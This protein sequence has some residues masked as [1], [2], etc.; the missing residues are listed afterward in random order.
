MWIFQGLKPYDA[1]K[2]LFAGVSA[3][4]LSSMFL[5]FLVKSLLTPVR[6]TFRVYRDVEGLAD[7]VARVTLRLKLLVTFVSLVCLTLT[8]SAMMF[9]ERTQRALSKADVQMGR[10]VFNRLLDHVAQ[11]PEDQISEEG[12]RLLA[13]DAGL[14]HT[15]AAFVFDLEGNPVATTGEERLRHFVLDA[16]SRPEGE[17]PSSFHRPTSTLAT[18]VPGRPWHLAIFFPARLV[19]QGQAELSQTLFVQLALSLSIAIGL[20]VLAANDVN[21]AIQKIGAWSKRVARGNLGAPL[22]IEGEDEL[23]ELSVYLSNMSRRLGQMILQVRSTTAGVEKMS[24]DV[25]TVGQAVMNSSEEQTSGVL[26]ATSVFEEMSASIKGIAE[27][28]ERL[29]VSAEES[30]SS[31]LEMGATVDE[32]SGNMEGLSRS[33]EESVSSIEQMTSAVREVARNVEGLAEVAEQ[34]SSSM[35]EMATTIKQVEE[36]ALESRR[37][38][39]EMVGASQQ[40]SERMSATIVGIEAIRGASEEAQRVITSLGRRAEEIGEIVDVID[41][42]A[43][44]TNLLALN[45]A[46]IAA[47]AGE[48]GRGF[49]VV[50]DEIKDLA[51]RVGSSTKEIGK[52][53]RAVQDESGNAVGA[54]R[55]GSELVAEGERLSQDAG[56]ALEEI[57]TSARRSGEMIGEIAQATAEQSKGSESVV[58]AM[59][60]VARDGDADP[61]GDGGADAGVGAGDG[62]VDVDARRDPAGEGDDS[63]AGPRV[64]A[65]HD[66]HRE[67]PG[68][69]PAYPQRRPEPARRGLACGRDAREDPRAGR[70]RR[71]PGRQ[72]ERGA[73]RY[74]RPDRPRDPRDRNSASLRLLQRWPRRE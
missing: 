24:S 21:Q 14:E 45:A 58:L 52:L 65:D 61:G 48:H 73:P 74:P 71:G 31:I 39:E 55:R 26:E 63:R 11:L 25:E 57:T 13:R 40:G 7:G 72:R 9:Y 2:I 15:A 5:F 10:P 64:G 38:S 29:S 43:E 19:A 36:N 51:E 20:A 59:E 17:Q 23:G 18:R 34:T 41:E 3:G 44:E 42:V 50:A 12:L 69:G 16:A 54:V 33:V 35:D 49:S 6:D 67:H 37:L 68:N 1:S 53:I 22:E 47:Q 56:R 30:S 62:G 66:E 60:R 4:Y 70:E 8:F 46:I 28:T 27:N 32:V